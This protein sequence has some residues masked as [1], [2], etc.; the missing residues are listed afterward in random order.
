M[1]LL[2][3]V[4][5]AFTT[6]ILWGLSDLITKISLTK[7]RKWK[8]LLLSQFFGGLV[9]LVYGL[10]IGEDFTKILRLELFYLILIGLLNTFGMATFY[11]SMKMKGIALTSPITNSW[12]IVT[13]ILG[14][15]FYH[16]SVSFLQGIAVIL[17]I[18]GIITMGLKEGKKISFDTTLVYAIIS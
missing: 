17:I 3:G 8:V 15:I 10:I 14:I 6:L 11:K 7:D 16:E 9:V 5:L 12:P 13:I 18:G 2:I 4:L 1:A